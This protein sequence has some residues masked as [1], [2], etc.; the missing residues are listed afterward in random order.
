M[1]AKTLGRC[2]TC[3]T[4]VSPELALRWRGYWWHCPCWR[5]TFPTPGQVIPPTILTPLE[6]MPDGL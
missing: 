3:D 6:D 4:E 5:Y 1:I 2:A